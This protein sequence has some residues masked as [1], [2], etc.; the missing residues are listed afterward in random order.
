MSY[1]EEEVEEEQ[2]QQQTEKKEEFVLHKTFVLTCC[3]MT[4]SVIILVFD[5]YIFK[6][7]RINRLGFNNFK[8]LTIRSTQTFIFF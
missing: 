5:L 7:E 2:Q 4:N 8:C 6:T 3:Y 1:R